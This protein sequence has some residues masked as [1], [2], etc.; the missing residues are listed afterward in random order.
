MACPQ[1]LELSGNIQHLTS[2]VPPLTDSRVGLPFTD[3]SYTWR[4]EQPRCQSRSHTHVELTVL[5]I[6]WLGRPK[7]VKCETCPEYAGWVGG[8]KYGVVID[9]KAAQC[10][11]G[12]AQVMYLDTTLMAALLETGSV[13]LQRTCPADNPTPTPQTIMLC[14]LGYLRLYLVNKPQSPEQ[15]I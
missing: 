14:Y 13:E 15:R 7:E 9:L 2:G 1:S 5:F 12:L 4:A 3:R 11:E 6:Y 10:G 8:Y